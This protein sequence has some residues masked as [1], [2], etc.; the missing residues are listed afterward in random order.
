M[1]SYGVSY[2]QCPICDQ[3]LHCEYSGSIEGSLAE[4]Q[5]VCK[6]DNH[7]Y[8]YV[9]AYGVTETCIDKTIIREHW[10]D[11]KSVRDFNSSIIEST[12][13]HARNRYKERVG[14]N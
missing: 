14:I 2:G 6:N 11:S 1:Y 4:E 9:Y 3:E 12:I 13:K 8:G 10:D 5:V 7:S